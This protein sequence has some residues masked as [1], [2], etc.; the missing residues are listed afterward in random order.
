MVAS[1]KNCCINNRIRNPKFA[2][3]QLSQNLNLCAV[4]M[5]SFL[6]MTK[7]LLA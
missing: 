7:A 5:K 4:D 2:T 6:Q 3:S 1:N